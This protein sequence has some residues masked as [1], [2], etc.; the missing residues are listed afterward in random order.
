MLRK[1]WKVI[2][3]MLVLPIMPLFMWGPFT[4]PIINKLA[5]EKA[6]KR[7]KNGDKNINPLIIET[8]NKHAETFYFAG[9]SPDAI[10]IN[11]ILT[12]ISVYDYTH[13][14]HPDNVWGSPVFGYQL[15]NRWVKSGKYPYK[16]LAIAC[17]WLSHQVADWFAHYAAF[18]E[19]GN[20]LDNPY[21]ESNNTTIFSG[22]SNSHRVFGT[23]YNPVILDKYSITNHAL[24]E[25]F[26]DLIL[27][28]KYKDSLLKDTRVELFD[29][30]SS[31]NLLTYTSEFYKGTA[32]R[33]PPGEIALMKENFTF[34]IGGM[35]VLLNLC[36]AIRPEL[37]DL[38]YS[39]YKDACLPQ[40]VDSVVDKVFCLPTETIDKH[41][42]YHTD[43]NDI[44]APVKVE[45][46]QRSGT[47]LFPIVHKLGASIDPKKLTP[48]ISGK[49]IKISF[50]WGL[51]Q[52]RLGFIFN[53]MKS[54]AISNL[55][56]LSNRE[57]SGELLAYISKLL[58]DNENNLNSPLE[59]YRSN[60]RPIIKLHGNESHNEQ[61]LLTTMFQQKN[62]KFRVYPPIYYGDHEN[63]SSKKINPHS[64]T[65]RLNG[66]EVTKHTK[67][68][69]LNIKSNN[70]ILDISCRI[71]RDITPGQYHIT[72]NIKD[73]S[74]IVS[75][76]LD[77]EIMVSKL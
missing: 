12:N 65:L 72:I 35:E 56:K 32:V 55:R 75:N 41:V 25:F 4:H 30:E 77:Y 63:S 13:N 66:Y 42:V 26:Y 43:H 31:D 24:I 22:Y 34:V 44:I 64:L 6:Q 70:D 71:L 51:L 33:I 45:R 17:G 53:F 50:F 3:L 68:F 57:D 20:L 37:P 19:K 27:F 21:Q 60:L 48:Y 8:I 14:Y 18:D 52:L 9:N 38:L 39:I 61:K 2:K 16:D 67:D 59:N 76:T 54:L 46:I 10:A 74:G 69:Q 23:E 58:V 62:I 47:I 5:H 15:I 49:P 1:I 29:H 11:N 73:E 40:V 28:S 7:Y 36:L